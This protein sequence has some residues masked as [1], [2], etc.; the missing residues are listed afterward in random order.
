MMLKNKETWAERNA[1]GSAQGT[2]DHLGRSRRRSHQGFEMKSDFRR[3]T[4]QVRQGIAAFQLARTK[5]AVRTLSFASDSIGMGTVAL[6]RGML[7]CWPD[8]S[9]SRRRR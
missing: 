7:L 4:G 9:R 2:T 3:R 8:R 5:R 1:A 6:D